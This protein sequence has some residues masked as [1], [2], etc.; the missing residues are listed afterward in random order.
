MIFELLFSVCLFLFAGYCLFYVSTTVTV[1]TVSDPLGAALWP[2]ILLVLLLLVLA[3][4]MYHIVR[5]MPREERN[6]KRLVSMDWKKALASPLFLG[7][8]T[9]LVYAWFLNITGFL[10]TSWVLC[11]ICCCLLGERRPVVI[12][13]FSLATVAVLFLLFYKGMGIQMPRGTVPFLR[14]LALAIESLLRS[15]G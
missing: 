9:L 14:N 2:Q 3:L 8:V 12:P 7:M 13:V 4:N 5:N 10:L 6:L 15:I 11:M 1:S